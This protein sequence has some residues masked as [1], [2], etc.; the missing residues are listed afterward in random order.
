VNGAEA[1]QFPRVFS[2]HETDFEKVRTATALYTS[3]GIPEYTDTEIPLLQSRDDHRQGDHAG[4][5]L[6]LDAGDPY[7]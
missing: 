5:G 7:S 6:Y 3:P 2:H 1:A 4:P